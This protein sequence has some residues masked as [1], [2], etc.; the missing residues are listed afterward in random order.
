MLWKSSG[1]ILDSKLS[2]FLLLL[3]SEFYGDLEYKFRKNKG[4]TDFFLIKKS[5]LYS[6]IIYMYIICMYSGIQFSLLKLM[7]DPPRFNW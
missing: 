4:W 5:Y 3:F 7:L 1:L 6:M 2:S